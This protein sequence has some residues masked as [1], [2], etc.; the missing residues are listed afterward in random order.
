MA[1]FPPAASPK[2]IQPSTYIVALFIQIVRDGYGATMNA[3]NAAGKSGNEPD[4]AADSS[5][6]RIV[7][8]KSLPTRL[9]AARFMRV[10]ESVSAPPSEQLIRY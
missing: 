5:I 8:T 1:H 9:I 2:T 10:T 4:S 3:Y 7:R 6:W